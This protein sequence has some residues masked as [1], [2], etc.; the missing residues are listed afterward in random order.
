MVPIYAAFEPAK[1]SHGCRDTR[2]IVFLE[3]RELEQPVAIQNSVEENLREP[4]RA[5]EMLC[6]RTGHC[7]ACLKR[8]SRSSRGCRAST[9]ASIGRHGL[10]AGQGPAHPILHLACQARRDFD[11]ISMTSAGIVDI[12]PALLLL[13]KR[14]VSLT[15]RRD[16]RFAQNKGLALLRVDPPRINCTTVVVSVRC[17]SSATSR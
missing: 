6:N 13:N 17:T 9:S 16:I 4:E 7:E 8:T 2:A 11:S 1:S 12:V 5:W 14:K 3:E 10:Y 15:P